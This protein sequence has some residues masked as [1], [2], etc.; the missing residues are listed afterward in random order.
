MK[1]ADL[2]PAPHNPRRLSAEQESALKQALEVFGDLGGIVFNRRSGVLV[3]GHQRV[4]TLDPDWPI[5]SSAHALLEGDQKVGTIARGWIDT[6]FGRLS[7]REVDWEERIEKAAMIA[8]N[9]AGGEWDDSA[10]KPLVVTLDD[11]S[12]ILALTGFGEVELAGLI[13]RGAAELPELPSESEKLFQQMNF[14][15]T[16]EQAALIQAT[17]SRALQKGPFSGTGNE[18]RNANALARICEAYR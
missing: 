10:L 9:K 11:G 1:V 18:N 16:K 17:I 8:A 13:E 14:V 7:Y 6:P 2:K 5:T 12:G 4:K 3:S 15:V